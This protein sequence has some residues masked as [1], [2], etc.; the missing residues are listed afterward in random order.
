MGYISN[1]DIRIIVLVDPDQA[2]QLRLMSNSSRQLKPVPYQ[3]VKFEN[4]DMRWSLQHLNPERPD[5]FT[6]RNER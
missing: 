1:D 6:T 2:D 4:V 5:V 3:Q